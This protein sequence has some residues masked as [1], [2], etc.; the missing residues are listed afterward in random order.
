MSDVLKTHDRLR[1]NGCL[2]VEVVECIQITCCRRLKDRAVD[3]DKRSVDLQTKRLSGVPCIDYLEVYGV[4]DVVDACNPEQWVETALE[5]YDRQCL[6]TLMCIEHHLLPVTDAPEVVCR[7]CVEEDVIRRA[8]VSVE[9]L[10]QWRKARELERV[11]VPF[12]TNRKDGFG[13]SGY[14]ARM[15]DASHAGV[16]RRVVRSLVDSRDV[17]LHQ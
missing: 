16:V 9:V 1:Y 15:R 4:G 3:R 12:A 14:H 13:D 10:D 8:P 2:V 11:R 17:V 7:V 6:R 5:G